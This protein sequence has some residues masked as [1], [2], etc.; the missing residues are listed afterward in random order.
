MICVGFGCHDVYTAVKQ[1]NRL[2]PVVT[3]D[4][5]LFD[6]PAR[7][8]VEARLAGL[9]AKTSCLVYSGPRQREAVDK[10]AGII[11]TC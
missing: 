5:E 4:I 9:V 6:S 3:L 7:N 10:E 1:Q 2:D 8:G 11:S